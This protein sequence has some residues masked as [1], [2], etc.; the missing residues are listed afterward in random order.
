MA[1]I[2]NPIEDIALFDLDGT[3]CDYEKA[4][5]HSLEKLSSPEEQPIIF[6]IR[7]NSPVYLRNRT[8]IIRQSEEWWINLP[9]LQLGWDVLAV[10]QELNY[11]I[12]VLTQGPRTNPSAWSGKKR[13]ADLNL[14]DVDLTITRDKGL[15][16]GKVL[17]DDFPE[18]I[19]RW[20]T[21]RKRGLVIM[22]TSE[23]NK[24][25]R[26]PQVIRYDGTRD[27]LEEVKEAMLKAKQ[28]NS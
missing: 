4:L 7:D 26:H 18:Y 1:S 5:K 14:P 6:P 23:E 3:L 17:V 19:E 10:A 20:L 25:Y 28:R 27:C 24:N 9:K 2:T 22:P 11:R 21:W 12:M 16:Y 15:V 13:W 8:K